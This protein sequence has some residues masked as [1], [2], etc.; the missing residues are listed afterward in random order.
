MVS[1]AIG[2]MEI[3]RCANE[4]PCCAKYACVFCL[5]FETDE[6]MSSAKRCEWL[7]VQDAAKEIQVDVERS[8]P[9][10]EVSNLFAAA[11]EACVG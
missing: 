4:L 7:N 5:G 1:I 9:E 8:A 2:L 6:A 11:A 10:N 3:E